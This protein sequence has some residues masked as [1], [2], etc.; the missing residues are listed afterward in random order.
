MKKLLR[1]FRVTLPCG[2]SLTAVL[3]VV[4][5]K[6]TDSCDNSQATTFAYRT[7]GCD[8]ECTHEWPKANL[9]YLFRVPS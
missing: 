9:N 7:K 1:V 8:W 2:S 5:N 4:G 6:L 3:L